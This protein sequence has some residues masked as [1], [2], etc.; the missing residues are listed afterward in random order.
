MLD[1]SIIL[2]FEIT[3]EEDM[4]LGFI[5]AGNM[6]NAILTGLFKSNI[7]SPKDVFVSNKSDGKLNVIKEKFGTNVSTDN[8]TV[9]KSAVDAVFI[10]VKP[11]VFD[12][13]SE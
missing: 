7:C 2:L 3:M 1:V 5:G 8:T 4:K 9:L 11:Q 10:C 6:A 13:I 12:C